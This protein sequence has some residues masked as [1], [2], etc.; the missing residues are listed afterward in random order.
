MKVAVYGT[1]KSGYGN[2]DLLRDAKFIQN[3]WIGVDAV[4]GHSYPMAKI[5]PK[6][7]IFLAAEVYEINDGIL[8]M[9]DMLEGEGVL[10]KR[11]EAL[12]LHG[13][14]VFVYH[15]IARVHSFS[16]V[17]VEAVDEEGNQYYS[18]PSYTEA[19]DIPTET[20]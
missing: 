15:I 5:N 7:K 18:W 8:K 2:H 1:L 20:D 19:T 9:L 12:T 3:D 16:N 11:I 6:S 13:Q 10:Y 17:D 14:D 4:G